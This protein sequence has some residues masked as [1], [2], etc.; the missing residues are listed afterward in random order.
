ME[1]D[2]TSLIQYDGPKF[3]R[4]YWAAVGAYLGSLS[5]GTALGYSSTALPGMKLQSSQLIL[6]SKSLQSWFA[7]I[8]ALAALFGG[9]IA[10][11]SIEKIGRRLTLMLLSVPF[12]AGW[13]C[14]AYATKVQVLLIGRAL[15]GFSCGGCTLA[16]SIFISETVPTNRRGLIGSGFQLFVG[17]GLVASYVAG[18]YLSWPWHAVYAT[19]YPLGMLCV[20]GALHET[21]TWLSLKGRHE[22]AMIAYVFFRQTPP[23]SAPIIVKENQSDN[24]LDSFSSF[25]SPSIYKPFLLVLF[26]MFGQQFSGINAVLFYTVDIFHSSGSTINDNLATIIIG[27]IQVIA[28]FIACILTDRLGR[29]FLLI[30]S[31]IF[32]GLSLLV[33]TLYYHLS[34]VHGKSFSD[35][36]GW[37]PLT[38]LA[39]YTSAFSLGFG[40]LPW[41]L[42]SELLP[43]Q[44][45]GVA[46]GIATA[47]NWLGCFIVSKEFASY[48]DLVGKAGTFG[49][50]GTIC[51][52]CALIVA[53]ILPETKGKSLQEIQRIF[54]PK[55]PKI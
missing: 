6:T 17:V 47:F 55:E 14:I 51:I 43:A 26:I 5:I 40:P 44:V 16:C 45:K 4:Y 24:C 3:P 7:S 15:T 9:I 54:S 33:L 31:G 27:V 11:Q 18:N 41:L 22:A 25:R 35:S 50:F 53:W 42:M 2:T 19:I 1:V 20:V 48:Q 13:L 36:Y 34:D 49:T 38:S 46:S 12:V 21:P 23:E 8:L 39:I 37:L 28:T 29:R 32:M 52:I 30:A 10:G